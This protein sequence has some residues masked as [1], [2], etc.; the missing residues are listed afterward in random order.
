MTEARKHEHE[1]RH[2]GGDGHSHEHAHSHSPGHQHAHPG[3]GMSNRRRLFFVLGLTIAYMLAEAIGGFLTNSLALISDA[4]HMLTDI[5]A[6]LLAILALWFAS[7]PVTHSKTYGYYRMEILAALAN[8]VALVAISLVLFYE[9]IQRIHNPPEVRGLEVMVI[10]GGGLVTNLISAWLLH[11][12]SREN[13]NMRGA[14]LHVA[15]DALGSIGALV[16]GALIWQKG[17]LL[18]DPIVSLIMCVLIIFSSWQLIRDAVNVL[19]EGTPSHIDVPALIEAMHE[20]EHVRQVHDLHVWTISSGKDALSAH[21][22]TSPG[23]SHRSV[24]EALQEKLR[25][26]FNIGHLTIQI[27]AQ[28][29][30]E[31]DGVTLYQIIRRS[32]TELDATGARV[33]G[34]GTPAR[35][36]KN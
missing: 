16:A 35:H 12:G 8:G 31:D 25:T 28:E 29:T 6:L 18:A 9:A 24:L 1:H 26:E 3:A 14:F 5:A 4:G 33:G 34:E 22:K 32:G 7:R 13:L 15:S 11:A 20:V 17:L 27:E 23:S 19:L 21:V 2:G 36:G 10:A 30:T